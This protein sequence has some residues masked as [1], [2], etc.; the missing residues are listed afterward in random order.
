MPVFVGEDDCSF[1]WVGHAGLLGH[2]EGLFEDAL[3]GGS[4]IVVEGGEL[5]GEVGGALTCGSG[6]E[7]E[8]I[9]GVPEAAYGVEAGG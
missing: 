1:V 4:S 9:G 7:F 2:L 8:G 6:H 3:F 5:L